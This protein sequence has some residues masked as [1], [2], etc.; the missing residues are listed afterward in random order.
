GP[1]RAD[2]Y[3]SHPVTLLVPLGAG[4]V[5][6]VVARSIAA[7]LGDRLGKPVIIENRTGGGTIIAANAVA[8]APPD[9]YLLMVAPSG[10]LTTN[11]TLYKKLPYDPATDF[12]F[13]ALYC[14]VP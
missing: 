13:V 5:M 4:G 11:V 3:P 6:D 8:K 2:E 12:A 10:T 14:K 9:G 7:R 1:A